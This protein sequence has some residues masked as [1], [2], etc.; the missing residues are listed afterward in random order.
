VGGKGET[1]TETPCP[2]CGKPLERVTNGMKKSAVLI[3]RRCIPCNKS[4]PLN[5]E[6]TRKLNKTVE[7]SR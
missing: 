2:I 4:Y 6:E 5:E 3:G 7:A 1:M